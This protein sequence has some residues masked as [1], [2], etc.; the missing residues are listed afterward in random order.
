MEAPSKSIPIHG[1]A[2]THTWETFFKVQPPAMSRSRNDKRPFRELEKAHVRKRPSPDGLDNIMNGVIMKVGLNNVVNSEDWEF[3]FNHV[4]NCEG[5]ADF[6]PDMKSR[7]NPSSS[8][9]GSEGAEQTKSCTEEAKESV[10]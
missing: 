10:T 4:K 1:L 8:R 6:K 7:S 9:T 2:E 3:G 5:L